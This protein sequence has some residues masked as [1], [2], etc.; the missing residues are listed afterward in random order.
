MHLPIFFIVASLT[1]C[2]SVREEVE[3]L[4]DISKI[5]QHQTMMKYNKAWTFAH[6]FLRCAVLI[7]KSKWQPLVQPVTEKQSKWH[8]HFSVDPYHWPNIAAVITIQ[9]CI[10]SNCST[11]RWANSSHCYA[12]SHYFSSSSSNRESAA[13]TSSVNS[14]AKINILL[15]VSLCLDT[16]HRFLKAICVFHLFKCYHFSLIPKDSDPVYDTIFCT[17]GSQF[18][19]CIHPKSH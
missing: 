4:K 10:Q 17:L 13:V 15:S 5:N 18:S 6:T 19:I 1:H 2:P 16:R 9:A 3:A 12:V 11:N 7:W 14:A 8:F